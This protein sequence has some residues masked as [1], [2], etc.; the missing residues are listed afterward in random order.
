[1]ET[2]QREKEEVEQQAAQIRADLAKSRG[3]VIVV[4]SDDDDDDDEDEDD[5][6][7]I[8]GEDRDDSSTEVQAGKFLCMHD[9]SVSC[10]VI[11][12]SSTYSSSN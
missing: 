5:V 9:I 4:E 10:V 7:S 8:D 2:R 11:C 6:E 3:E 12:V 1:L